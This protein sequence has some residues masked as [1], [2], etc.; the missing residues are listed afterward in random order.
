[1]TSTPDKAAQLAHLAAQPAD[2]A[3]FQRAALLSAGRIDM[4]ME[5]QGLVAGRA[6][7]ADVHAFIERCKASAPSSID[8]VIA[9]VGKALGVSVSTAAERLQAMQ[10][11]AA[12][13]QTV[14]LKEVLRRIDG[15]PLAKTASAP[16]GGD[17]FMPFVFGAFVGYELS[18]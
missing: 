7:R 13:E 6:P 15:L 11:A 10:I 17:S 12:H 14:L 8:D 3:L 4:S 16:A 5:L 1:M 18:K 9:S 2:E